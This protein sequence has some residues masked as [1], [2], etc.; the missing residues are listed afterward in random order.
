MKSSIDF[1][2][3]L[4]TILSLLKFGHPALFWVNYSFDCKTHEGGLTGNF[5]CGQDNIYTVEKV[6]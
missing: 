2:H 1:F 4:N 3:G 5:E 6:Y